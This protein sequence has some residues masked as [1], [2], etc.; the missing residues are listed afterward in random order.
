MKRSSS[1]LKPLLLL[2]LLFQWLS[3]RA[4][5]C[6]DFNNN[7]IGNWQENAAVISISSDAPLPP[8]GTS[9]LRVRDWFS[10]QTSVLYNTSYNASVIT[11]GNIC[12]DYKI[13][14]D[15]VANSVESIS[16]TIRITATVNGQTLTATFRLFTP[17][18]EN[19]AWMNIC[20]PLSRVGPGA[21]LP[22][23]AQGAWVMVSGTNAD[24]NT[25]VNNFSRVQFL[26]DVAGSSSQDEFIGIDNFCVRAASCCDVFNAPNMFG[27]WQK[28]NAGMVIINDNQTQDG[29]S[30]LYVYDDSNA[31]S[32]FNTSYNATTVGC[33]SFCF[34]YRIFNDGWFST[35]SQVVNTIRISA[36]VNGV[37][38]A[39]VFQLNNPITENSGWINI[40]APLGLGATPPGNTQGN[41]VMQQGTNAQW[42]TLVQNYTQV[43]FSVDVAGSPA[44]Q[45]TIGLDNFCAVPGYCCDPNPT[46]AFTI[47]KTCVN[48]VMQ[49]T[50]TATDQFSG[51]SHWWGLMETS[52]CG[53]TGD[54]TTVDGNPATP[55]TLDPVQPVQGGTSAT[56]SI[57]DYSKCYYIKHGIW[58]D[59]C[60]GW[61]E[62]RLP[63]EPINAIN[64]FFLENASGTHKTEFCYGEDVFLDG[65]LSNGENAYYI[66]IWRRPAVNG[67]AFQ[68]YKGLGWFSG[69][70]GTINLSQLM[71]GLTPP[72]MF[73]PGYEYQ[74]KLALQNLPNC[75][76]WTERLRTFTVVCC[77]GV[78]DGCF[79]IEPDWGTNTYAMSAIN[80]NTYASAGVVHEWYVF[81]SP[82][83]GTGPY[84]H[85]ATITSTTETV[86]PLYNSALP[87]ITYTVIHRMKTPC[88]DVCVK[89]VQYQGKGESPKDGAVET[90][91]CQ[92]VDCSLLDTLLNNCPAPLN[93]VSDCEKQAL[94][95]DAVTGATGYR[96]EISYND[97]NCCRTVLFPTGSLYSV[98]NNYLE[99]KTIIAPVFDCLRWRVAAFCGDSTSPWSEWKCYGCKTEGAGK[100]MLATKTDDMIT[101][102]V[103]SPN[104][105]NGTM[106]LLL[107]TPGSLDIAVEVY[108]TYGK[109]VQQLKQKN[110]PGGQFSET[111]RM[112]STE[113]GLYTI[114]FKTN[115]GTFN[116]KVIVQ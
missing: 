95:W 90:P 110:I 115:Y 13:F 60:F 54:A 29:T 16:N 102:P 53:A 41:W 78:L 63:V 104:P 12:F 94:R 62:L 19:S 74:V 33:G 20:V 79:R 65:S 38:L 6:E 105:N 92:K 97:P 107:K 69:Q 82:N 61:Q 55:N 22:S 21:A 18:T 109:L 99:L 88:G 103:V 83:F 25:L 59:S 5:S 56:F 17:I 36:T 72:G 28:T 23:N 67:G 46:P 80:F 10:S 98:T 44:Q 51:T 91:G 32:I 84:T 87:D 113:K 26:T 58:Q 96:V 66:D 116:K 15:G 34:D 4:Q 30:Y 108:N 50:V 45:E 24:W 49:V 7:S 31:S 35:T 42:N 100:K 40:C 114:V 27:N 93:L 111:L 75:I 14:N 3:P 47:Q 76:G 77:D 43:S 71:G 37:P 52:L 101:E 9:Y 73:E 11:C 112:P 8:D 68:W 1:F 106:T 89:V 64:I 70:V 85:L 2:L 48:G 81:S 57:S 86:V 39:A